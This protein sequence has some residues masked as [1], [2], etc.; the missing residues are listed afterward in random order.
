VKVLV[1]RPEAAADVEEAYS[2]YERHRAGLGAEFLV[3]LQAGET[4]YEPRLS[5][6]RFIGETLVAIVFDASHIN[7]STASSAS[8]SSSSLASMSGGRLTVSR[9]AVDG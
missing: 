4:Q 5:P 2:W 3:A 8:R 9:H 7:S 6:I 1:Y